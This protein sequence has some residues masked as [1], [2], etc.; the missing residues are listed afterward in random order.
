MHGILDTIRRVQR[1][2]RSDYRDA[3][4]ALIRATIEREQSETKAL[5]VE[6][7]RSEEFRARV[8]AADADNAAQLKA[9]NASKTCS[10]GTFNAQRE[11]HDRAMKAVFARRKQGLPSEVRFSS[12]RTRFIAAQIQCEA[13]KKG[14]EKDPQSWANMTRDDGRGQARL[15]KLRETSKGAIY[16]LRIRTA[17]GWVCAKVHMRGWELPVDARIPTV[18]L[19]ATPVGHGW[20]WHACITVVGSWPERE[21][22]PGAV[23]YDW[24]HREGTD[25]SVRA[26]YY[27]TSDG[28]HGEIRLPPTV[29]RALDRANEV[30]SERSRLL[31]DARG[32]VPEMGRSRS[33]R[34]LLRAIRSTPT[35]A[36]VLLAYLGE[37]TRLAT[38]E[39]NL[40]RKAY[41]IRTEVYRR[42]TRSLNY[43][44]RAIEALKK[45]TMKKMGVEGMTARRGRANR[46]LVAASEFERWSS[47]TISV[48]ARNTSKTCHVCGEINQIGSATTWKCSGC[49]TSHDRDHNAAINIMRRA[50]EKH[51]ASVRIEKDAA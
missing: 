50:L 49:G 32:L 9:L 38:Q 19:V 46:D 5:R 27:A 51:V 22:R 34:K 39:D 1:R 2:G 17:N 44:V 23:G 6:R 4:H 16:E 14:T 10:W 40:R 26:Y 43:E 15:V 7:D 47:P 37:E 48:P 45:D 3:L 30:R 18:R 31:D 28:E 41:N 21:L 29:R 25:G 36:A 33:P 24:G 8:K 35:T 20:R 11:A 42:A 12:D 13:D